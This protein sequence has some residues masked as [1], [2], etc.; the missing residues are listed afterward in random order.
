MRYDRL[1]LLFVSGFLAFCT[2]TAASASAFADAD[3]LLEQGRTTFEPSILA[4]QDVMLTWR[5]DR[6]VSASGEVEAF[7]PVAD[8]TAIGVRIDATIKP[9]DADAWLVRLKFQH[10][11]DQRLMLRSMAK[12]MLP[13]EPARWWSGYV[14]EQQ[15][16]FD[17]DD[18]ML[19]KW[20]PINA[21][22]GV[23]EPNDASDAPIGVGLGVHPHDIYSRVDISRDNA[24]PALALA[25]PFVL[26]PGQSF[27]VS[28]VVTA[29]DH[30]F[31][32]RDVVQRY[33]DLFPEAY[34]PAEGVDPRV[35]GPETSYMAWKPRNYE[36]QHPAGLIRRFTDGY[37]GWEWCYSPFIRGGDWAITEQWSVGW[38]N[39]ISGTW[40]HASVEK[41]E[42]RTHDRLANVEKYDSAPMY[43]VNVMY[44]ER[45]LI[46]EQFP[47]VVFDRRERKGWGQLM[48]TSTY[49]GWNAY[50]ELFAKGITEIPQK[51][52][53]VRGI[54]WDSAFGHRIL[55]TETAGVEATPYR[56]FD[57]GQIIAIEGAAHAY[58]FDLNHRHESASGYRMAN[59]VNLKL[60]S[61][62]FCHA[63]TD[64][65]LY[66]GSPNERPE[67]FARVESMKTRLGSKSIA[68]HKHLV[69]S[70]VRWIEWDRLA[71]EQIEGAFR[72]LHDDAILLSYFWGGY[73]APNM[74]AL[75]VERTFEAMPELLS[76]VCQGWQ[77][78]PKIVADGR[79]VVARYGDGVGA[80]I[81]L[82]NPT[83][84]PQTVKL[85]AH[86]DNWDDQIP[87]LLRTDG[88]TLKSTL[89]SQGTESQVTVPS[90]EVL[91]LRVAGAFPAMSLQGQLPL[92]LSSELRN[93]KPGLTTWAFTGSTEATVNLPITIYQPTG[94]VESQFVQLGNT[95]KL[96]P[97][98]ADSSQLDLNLN[99]GDWTIDFQSSNE[100]TRLS[101]FYV[102][103]LH[104]VQTLVT[105][106]QLAGLNLLGNDAT[107][108]PWL[109][110]LNNDTRK[111]MRQAA[112][113]L[114]SWASDA[115]GNITDKPAA[116]KIVTRNDATESSSRIDLQFGEP[117]ELAPHRARIQFKDAQL[118]VTAVND[119]ALL[120]A[121]R[122]LVRLLDQAYPYYG[123]LPEKDPYLKA[124]GLAGG[125][126]KRKPPEHVAGPTLEEWLVRGGLMKPAP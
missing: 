77:A 79:V 24:P 104:D 76:L 115:A 16:Q 1:R 20:F 15:G 32:N 51:F 61:P 26:D 44:S 11:G 92:E 21:A 110:V 47:D 3:S 105:S 91:V 125:V 64:T 63:R 107:S 85:F 60:V 35:L 8:P 120:Q 78:S 6:L 59:A 25:Q 69:P 80:R 62:Y 48:L 126:L 53:E 71:P 89:T 124:A 43:Y 93:N 27:D 101:K 68:W 40:T 98:A 99:T 87:L 74:P 94:T 18:V 9:L 86:A 39:P 46:E 2:I 29:F 38:N 122:E 45:T 118:T 22:L 28:Y 117:Q 103:H 54:G 57:K 12:L 84:E 72:Q 37:G 50:G 34:Q 123:H 70:G 19:S 81:V 100:T 52:P 42:Q 106:K 90:H 116:V 83:Y 112:R 14:D 96:Q 109:I 67:R 13:T 121:T 108:S 73:P 31:G 17:P 5:L 65:S 49:P 102:D 55:T 23:I 111:P 58:L 36:L 33:Y 75:G 41:A 56:S 7:K 113:M 4:D 119:A 30:R 114:A 66:E 95:L 10:D 82:I 88:Q 97:S